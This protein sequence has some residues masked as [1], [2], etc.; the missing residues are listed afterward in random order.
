MGGRS[1]VGRHYRSESY[2]MDGLDL[3]LKYSRFNGQE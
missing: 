1:W 2:P 3:M